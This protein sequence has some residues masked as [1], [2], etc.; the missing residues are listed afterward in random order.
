[1]NMI[2][3]IPFGYLGPAVNPG[4]QVKDPGQAGSILSHRDIYGQSD[5]SQSKYL[6]NPSDLLN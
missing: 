4:I 1:M 2:E 5:T 6:V 3:T